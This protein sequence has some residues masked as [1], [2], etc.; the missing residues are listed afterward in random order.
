[1][2]VFQSISNFST[3]S[4][5]L[6]F[7]FTFIVISKS[8]TFLLPRHLTVFHVPLP[9]A[10]FAR[11]SVSILFQIPGNSIFLFRFF[12]LKI[13]RPI[14]S[15]CAVVCN[16]IIK[17]LRYGICLGGKIPGTFVFVMEFGL[18]FRLVYFTPSL[19]CN[20]LIVFFTLSGD[21]FV[22]ACVQKTIVRGTT[23]S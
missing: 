4:C 3:S 16:T 9:G 14:L 5:T 17:F 2:F 13:S 23:R 8:T 6:L 22:R 11:F 12:G 19:L 7:I 21:L 1:M 10:C 20:F 15:S 18:N